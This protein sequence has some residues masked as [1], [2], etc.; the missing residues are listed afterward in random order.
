MFA[1]DVTFVFSLVK[2][3]AY[4]LSQKGVWISKFAVFV[5]CRLIAQPL[6]FY[7][8]RENGFLVSH[9]TRVPYCV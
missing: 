2:G 6:T 7:V 1:F 3:F 8:A 9:L 4:A 5:I